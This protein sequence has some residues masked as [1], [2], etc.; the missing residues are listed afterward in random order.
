[1]ISN[2]VNLPDSTR[3]IHTAWHSGRRKIKDL[4]ILSSFAFLIMLFYKLVV[5]WLPQSV[6]KSRSTFAKNVRRHLAG[7]IGRSTSCAIVRIPI[8]EMLKPRHMGQADFIVERHD[9]R[10]GWIESRPIWK[11]LRHRA[12][13]TGEFHPGSADRLA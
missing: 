10:R 4:C 5:K 8:M 7:S 13:G 11:T 9:T 3:R 1:L 12:A 2:C 6:L